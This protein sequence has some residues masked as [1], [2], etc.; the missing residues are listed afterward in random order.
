MFTNIEDG[1]TR[2]I[3]SQSRAAEVVQNKAPLLP[4]PP[5]ICIP[6]LT[7]CIGHNTLHVNSFRNR[8]EIINI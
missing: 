1:V 6:Q 8:K 4:D 2:L 3:R 5:L 7:H